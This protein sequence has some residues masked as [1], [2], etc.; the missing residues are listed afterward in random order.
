MLS[1]EELNSLSPEQQK[2]LRL[3]LKEDGVDVSKLPICSQSRNHN[4]PFPATY[5]QRQLWFLN[6]LE[7]ASIAYN[8]LA[9]FKLTGVLDFLLLERCFK[10]IIE[11]HETLRTAFATSDNYP[12]QIIL[13][14]QQSSIIE[15]V[16]FS[17]LNDELAQS[18]I[19]DLT[20]KIAHTQFNLQIGPLIKVVVAKKSATENIL[21]VVLHHIIADGWSIH[22]LAQELNSYYQFYSKNIP[23]A[24]PALAIQYADYAVWQQTILADHCYAQDLNYWQE[25][26][27]DPSVL[28]L[29]LDYPRSA[30]KTSNGA[31]LKFTLPAALYEKIKLIS[32]QQ[33]LSLFVFLLTAFQILLHRYSSQEDILLG[34]VL[35]TRTRSELENLIGLFSNTIVLRA[36]LSNNPKFS[37]VVV[38]N[39]A[40]VLKGFEH[41]TLPFEK[42]VESLPYIRDISQ[43]PFFQVMFVYQDAVV[44]NEFHIGD[45]QANQ[46]EIKQRGSKFD[47]TLFLEEQGQDLEGLFEYNTDLFKPETILGYKE[48]FLTLLENIVADINKPLSQLDILSSKQQQMFTQ[49]FDTSGTAKNYCVHQLFEAQV[50]LN[51]NAIAIRYRNDAISYNQLNELANKIAHGLVRLGLASEQPVAVMLETGIMQIAALLAINKAAGV[52]VCLDAN[53]PVGRMKQILQEVKPSFILTTATCLKKTE[54]QLL[55]SQAEEQYEAIIANIV[56]NDPASLIPK[57]RYFT[58]DYFKDASVANLNLKIPV[59]APVYVVY[60]SG[61]TGKPKGILQAQ[62]SS[63]QYMEWQST[64]FTI[65]LGSRMAQWAS[66]TYDASYSEIYGA[67]CF[68]ATLCISN[69][70]DRVDP[71]ALVNWLKNEAIN[72]VQLV[73]SFCKLILEL[74]MSKYP[75]AKDSGLESLKYMLL[76][77]ERL[78]VALAHT[79]RDYFNDGAQLYNL[80]GPSEIVLTTQYATH[81]LAKNAVTVPIGY[82]FSGRQI[83]ILDA[84]QCLCP[85][86]V[87]GEIYIKSP[88]LTLGYFRQALETAKVYI[89]NPLHNEY[90]DLVYKT[91]DRGLWRTMN[92]I[93]FLGRIDNQVKIRGSRVEIGE[94]EAALIQHPE[95]EEAAV[96]VFNDA[97][98]FPYLTAFITGGSNLTTIAVRNYLSEFL[99]AYMV[100]SVITMLDK[101]PRTITGKIDRKML[102]T[103]HNVN[104]T[105]D[106]DQSLPSTSLENAIANIWKKLLGLESV[107]IHANFFDLGGHSLLMVQVQ[108]QLNKLLNREIAL[109]DLFKFPS[110]YK[111]AH[112]LQAGASDKQTDSLAV[113][114]R[115]QLRQTLMQKRRQKVR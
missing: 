65:G 16:D 24:L 6:Q 113:Q 81:Q 32:K 44:K 30:S 111:L 55:S 57:N 8:M 94:V 66:I 103:T 69:E 43:H 50:E 38:Q 10:A 40:I 14:P 101:M 63:S 46:I 86:G 85:L 67:L 91:G 106:L 115:S 96:I 48:H 80:Y 33:D 42:L 92:E 5:A 26:L 13:S 20:E 7:P 11:R 49:W 87:P 27:K 64:Q 109:V 2:L 73:P 84:Y 53:Y 70:E 98:E 58:A 52:F 21:F 89:Q 22:I 95:I 88:Y 28:N 9:A 83:L 47:L 112:Y 82:P 59:S 54:Q 79:W 114:K 93:E 4:S 31:V 78:P 1:A 61:S 77:G 29:P 76:A 35:S 99:P 23:H 60:T 37:D 34:T 15:F 75:D 90:R 72:V 3:L 19:V 107:G 100:P 36:N 104:S 39:R 102:A 74:L 45:I 12:V 17:H 18:Q 68:G 62:A 105:Q 41:A 56:D 108:L 71:L 25:Q 51:P 97:E 110:I